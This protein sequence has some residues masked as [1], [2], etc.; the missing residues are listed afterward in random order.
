MIFLEKKINC[1]QVS[2]ITC[3]EHPLVG[4]IKQRKGDEKILI[5]EAH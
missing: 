4:E 2:L 5:S 1:L 3:S